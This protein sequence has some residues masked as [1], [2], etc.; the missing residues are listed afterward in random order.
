[1]AGVRAG[2]PFPALALP[3]L[4]GV[5]RPLA[6]AW[7]GGEALV[8]VGHRDCQTTRDTLPFLDR[9][10]R[11]RGAGTTV[12]LVL[13]DSPEAA[14]AL[15]KDLGLG[16]PVRL[17]VDPY[18][19][20]QAVGLAVVPTIFLIEAGGAIAHVSEGLR[21]SD[22][23]ALAQRVGVA[24]PLLAPEDGVPPLRPG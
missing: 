23:E 16:L 2:G 24:G 1:M 7:A 19:L 5:R 22:L 21:P 3:D 12:L 11:R 6:E 18:R 10:D 17:D 8:L 15:V 9:I 20:A 14:R 13:Q 4:E